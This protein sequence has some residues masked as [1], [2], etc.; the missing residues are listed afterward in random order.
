[1]AKRNSSMIQGDT[2]LLKQ[3]EFNLAQTL[4]S[5]QAFH[6]IPQGAGFLGLIGDLPVFIEQRGDEFLCVGDP[7]SVSHYFAFDQPLFEI[8]ASFPDD[9]AMQEALGFCR[10]LRIMR[11]LL[12]ESTLLSLLGGAG[13][14]LLALWGTALLVKWTPADIPRMDSVHFDPAVLLFTLG[15]TTAAGILMGLIPALEASRADHREAMQQSSRSVRGIS[16]SRVR[17]GSW[18]RPALLWMKRLPLSYLICRRM[19]FSL[20]EATATT[21]T[22]SA[23]RRT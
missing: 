1:M 22:P 15:L 3:P 2:H 19:I 18:F 7:D 23:A 10:G 5:G 4:A 9:P 14:V 17:F 21:R 20:T 16:R 13:G 6:W 8:Y 12:T 11:Q